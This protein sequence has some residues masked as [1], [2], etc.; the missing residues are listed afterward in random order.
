MTTETKLRYARQVRPEPPYD[1]EAI[2][3]YMP[4]N[5]WVR[6]DGVIEGEDH[7][8]WTLDGYVLP[9]LA[10]GLYFFEEVVE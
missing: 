1:R 7:A 2:E 3:R 9:R 4:D 5:Y 10:S 6:P 8:G